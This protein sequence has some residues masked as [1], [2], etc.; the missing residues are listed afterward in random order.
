MSLYC[1]SAAP[2]VTKRGA[3]REPIESR[4]PKTFAARCRGDSNWRK[5]AQLASQWNAPQSF[6]LF[7]MTRRSNGHIRFR[8][9]CYSLDTM[10][11]TFLSTC[12]N[13]VTLTVTPPK[14]IS[15]NNSKKKIQCHI[16]GRVQAEYQVDL[17]QMECYFQSSKPFIGRLLK[18]SAPLIKRCF[19]PFTYRT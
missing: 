3:K 6:S 15:W 19:L 14:K 18:G 17:W 2:K 11:C 8:T 10:I 13:G 12:H 5:G 16:I 1:K 7:K 9:E 4:D